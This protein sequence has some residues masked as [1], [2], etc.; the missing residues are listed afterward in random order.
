[1]FVC[2]ALFVKTD[3]LTAK[4]RKYS[5]SSPSCTPVLVACGISGGKIG[6]TGWEAVRIGIAVYIVSVAFVYN[7]A[8]LAKGTPL[9]ISVAFATAAIGSVLVVAG[10]RGFGVAG[11]PWW[12]RIL[13]LVG[14]LI[15]IGPENLWTN[16]LGLAL[17]FSGFIYQYL[18][19]KRALAVD[20]KNKEV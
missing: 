15:L 12:S 13:A 6:G 16:L 20:S 11:L 3:S 8:L 14:G 9:E 1:M 10:I 5:S 4:V 7:P 17:G 2:G 19:Q 18:F